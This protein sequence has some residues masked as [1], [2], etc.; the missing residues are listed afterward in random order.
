MATCAA[1]TLCAAAMPLTVGS[2][3][4]DESE[5]RGMMTDLTD[6]IMTQ[7]HGGK[8]VER[9]FREALSLVSD[10]SKNFLSSLGN[11]EKKLNLFYVKLAKLE[12]SCD[13]NSK[14]INELI[15]KIGEAE[16]DDKVLALDDKDEKLQKLG[17]LREQLEDLLEKTS[18]MGGYAKKGVSYADGCKTQLDEWRNRTY[19]TSTFPTGERAG[20]AILAGA[21]GSTVKTCVDIG[22]ALA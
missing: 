3:K 8:S 21:L 10:F 5:L 1:L 4:T 19:N 20:W 17:E 22:L 7:D 14:K 9:F 2:V 18:A 16:E 12:A 15:A 13:L 6:N 11:A